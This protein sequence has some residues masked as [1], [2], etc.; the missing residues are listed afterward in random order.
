MNYRYLSMNYLDTEQSNPI[1]VNLTDLGILAIKGNSAKSLLQGQVTCN[2]DEITPEQTRLGAQCNPQGRII[3][4]FRIFYMPEGYLLQM[5]R[6]LIPHALQALKKYAQFYKNLTLEDVSNSY[7]QMGYAGSGLEAYFPEVP[8]QLHEAVY[9]NNQTLILVDVDRYE[10]I[11]TQASLPASLSDKLKEAKP[12]H[13]WHSMNLAAGI[14]AIYPETTEQFLPHELNLP[15]LQAVSF[16]KGCY[17]GQEIIARMEYRGKLKKRL[18]FL[19]AHIP[20][21]PQRGKDIYCKGKRCGNIVDFCQLSYNEDTYDLLVV[22]DN[23]ENP[24]SL[25][26]D[27]EQTITVTSNV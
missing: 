26:L 23:P 27:Q 17:T 3:S 18:I 20:A 15:A 24:G 10:I 9:I 2:V 7:V 11:S 19:R 12:T 5:P 16:N 14:P 6:S 25:S 4:L 13:L 22:L 8:H 1:L 21:S